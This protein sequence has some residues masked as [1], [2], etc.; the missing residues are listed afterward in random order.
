ME[1]VKEIAHYIAEYLRYCRF[2]D[3][4]AS[5]GYY[6]I[7]EFENGTSREVDVYK[8]NI[9]GNPHYVIYCSYE[10]DGHDF[11]YT[12]DLSERQLFDKLEEL[13]KEN[14]EGEE[15][16][17]NTNK[18]PHEAVI[19]CNELES[20]LKKL[21]KQEI[22][23]LM[24]F[25]F[26]SPGFPVDIFQVDDMEDLDNLKQYIYY[27]VL[28]KQGP[29]EAELVL[30]K[31]SAITCGHEVIISW[32]MDCSWV[33]IIGDGSLESYFNTVRDNFKRLTK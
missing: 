3:V 6:T 13:Y 20:K 33:I 27:K 9:G 8:S 29:K 28:D 21:N 4:T 19:K 26:G 25:E 15:Y 1:H 23:E 12:D 32:S 31:I 5:S 16:M 14:E 7:K 11:K 30:D 22:E 10:D 17:T 18:T 2:D 24:L